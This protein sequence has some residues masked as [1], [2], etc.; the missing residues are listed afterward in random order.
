L[1][2]CGHPL[3]FYLH[4]ICRVEYS[5]YA[6]K[7]KDKVSEDIY[8]ESLNFY[9]NR[10]KIFNLENEFSGIIKFNT[11]RYKIYYWIIKI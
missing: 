3:R 4:D 2:K 6:Q 8:S 1:E 10:I 7:I 11:K 9:K 5:S